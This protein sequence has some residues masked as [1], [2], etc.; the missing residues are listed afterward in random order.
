MEVAAAGEGRRLRG[1]LAMTDII[2]GS[3]SFMASKLGSGER[4]LLLLLLLL[5]LEVVVT[6][7]DC[8]C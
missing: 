7:D 2:A 8:W 5:L 6:M 4:L 3:T 1:D